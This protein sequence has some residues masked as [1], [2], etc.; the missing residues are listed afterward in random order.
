M[1]GMN[2][3]QDSMAQLLTHQVKTQSIQ[4]IPYA[5]PTTTSLC[6]SSLHDWVLCESSKRSQGV[7]A[8]C[9][10]N[11]SAKFGRG[12]G[13]RRCLLQSNSG[14]FLSSAN[15]SFEFRA[16]MLS[17]SLHCVVGMADGRTEGLQ[18]WVWMLEDSRW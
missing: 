11:G 3:M 16:N 18:W 4:H 6:Y 9:M 1:N 15:L 8:G 13:G 7:A 5:N 14:T 12:C 2:R 10:A 17:H